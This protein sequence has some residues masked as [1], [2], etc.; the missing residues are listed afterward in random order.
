MKKFTALALALVLS[1]S[2]SSCGNNGTSS[3]DNSGSN[4]GDSAGK[5]Q[6][7]NLVIG[8]GHTVGSMEYLDSLDNFFKPEVAKRVSENTDYE[9]EWTDA[10]GTVA[11]LSETVTATQDGLLDLCVITV[12]PVSGQLPYHQYSIY[13]PFCTGDNALL[14]KVSDQLYE[15][16]SDELVTSFETQFTRSCWLRW[17][18]TPMRYFPPLP[19]RSSLT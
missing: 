17:F 19:S 4:S 7:I 6:T 15:E 12:S 16:F 5:K 14:Q 18:W 3:D 9:I 10:Y 8:A 1:L 11:G 2:L 13:L